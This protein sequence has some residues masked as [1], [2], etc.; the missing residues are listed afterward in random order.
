MYSIVLW[1]QF[2]D[3]GFSLGLKNKLAEAIAVNDWIR[4]KELVSTT[5]GLML[6]IFIPIC[7]SLEFVVPFVDWASFLNTSP[8]YNADIISALHICIAFL[9][10]RMVVGVINQ[11]VAAFQKTALSASFTMFANA[12]SLIVIYILPYYVKPSLFVL[13]FALVAP[14][15]IV[16]IVFSHIF[17]MGKFRKVCPDIRSFR[18]C[19]I[20]DLWNLGGKFFL[21]QIQVL[22]LFQ[23]TNFLIAHVSSPLD[24]TSYSIATTY[25]GYGLMI[26]STILVPLWPAFTDAY[27]K[28]DFVWMNKIYRKMTGLYGISAIL[29]IA[30]ILLSPMAYQL[31]IGDKARIPLLMTVCVGIYMLLRA[32]DSLQV[33]LINGVGK[34]KLQMYVTMIGL[35]LH[36]PLSLF[37]GQHIGALGV[38]V[39]MSFIT[40]IYSMFFTVQINKILKGTA[41]G[42]WSK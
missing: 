15:L 5:Y 21:I 32:W 2:F 11:V 35:T 12:I 16:L 17:Y 8:I 23:S 22:I 14:E 9:G 7:I 13:A 28:K 18:M 34:V 26:Y 4:G 37:L 31:W 30:M 24:V 36:I 38:V 25:L 6:L 33:Q 41:H 39:S 3:L 10:V 19:H 20:K 1:A 42:I 27:A 40:L 29:L